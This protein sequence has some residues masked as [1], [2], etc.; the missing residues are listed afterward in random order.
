MPESQVI[1][2]VLATFALGFIAGLLSLKLIRIFLKRVR[3]L[4]ARYRYFRKLN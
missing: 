2:I 1:Q 4:T 3:R